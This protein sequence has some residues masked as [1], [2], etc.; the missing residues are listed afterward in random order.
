MALS[1]GLAASI[2]KAL[3]HALK[4]KLSAILGREK[5]AGNLSPFIQ[6]V[7]KG[8]IVVGD[9]TSPRTYPYDIIWNDSSWLDLQLLLRDIGLFNN[10]ESLKESKRIKWLNPVSIKLV[11]I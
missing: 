8:T 2:L 9:A 10:V 6:S 4:D 7:V 1:L 11:L 5:E 3:D